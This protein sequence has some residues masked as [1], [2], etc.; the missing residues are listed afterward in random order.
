MKLFLPAL[1]AISL[2]ALKATTAKFGR[3][4]ESN[5]FFHELIKN[6]GN[7]Q[8]TYQITAFRNFFFC[9]PSHTKLSVSL[10]I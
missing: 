8:S 5:V 4:L 10:G 6:F 3:F 1:L 9:I 7:K 2:S